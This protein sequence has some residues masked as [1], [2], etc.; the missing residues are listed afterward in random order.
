MLSRSYLASTG[1]P[2]YGYELAQAVK[3]GYLV[4]FVSIETE[5]KFMN[6]GIA[7]DDLSPEEKDEYEKT[8]ADEDGNLPASIDSSALNQWLF[9]HDT[10]K[11]ALYIL[12]EHGQRVDFGAKIGKI[13][14]FSKNHSHAEKIL[15][16]WNKEFPDYPSHYC[17]VI[18]NYTNYAQ[19]LIDDFSDPKKYPQI[20]VSVDM[21]DTGEERVGGL[22]FERRSLCSRSNRRG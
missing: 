11:K 20:A 7:Y 1:V 9:N 12:M 19:S 8:F 18:D 14:V 10:I 6:E 2:T 3:D 22:L 16:I 21:L 17:R 13:I 5:L 4:D 15:E